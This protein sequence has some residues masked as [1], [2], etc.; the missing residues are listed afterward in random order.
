MRFSDILYKLLVIFTCSGSM[1]IL[2][3]KGEMLSI[4]MRLFF[5]AFAAM[6]VWEI[7]FKR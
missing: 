7:F 5:I 4:G 6:G 2:W 1:L 3:V